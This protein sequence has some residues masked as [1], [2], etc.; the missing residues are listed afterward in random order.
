MTTDL[1][2]LAGEI[3]WHPS[4]DR[5]RVEQFLEEAEA[6]SARLLAQIEAARQRIDRAAA[7]ASASTVEARARL[8]LQ[9]L[10][11]H[12]ELAETRRRNAAQVAKVLGDAE[13]Q[14]EEILAAARGEC[15]VDHP[16]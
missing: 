7:A 4:Y 13:A 15:P 14:A 16:R 8:G 9:V 6:E 5:A 10:E 1:F 11:A 2:R 3:T 12:R